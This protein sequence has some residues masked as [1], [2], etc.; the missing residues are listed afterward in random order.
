META[1]IELATIKQS[2][3]YNEL[4]V[5]R[6]FEKKDRRFDRSTGAYLFYSCISVHRRGWTRGDSGLNLSTAFIFHF[7]PKCR[8]WTNP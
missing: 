3:T 1:A 7:K 5:G 6:G 8:D 4:Q 2:G